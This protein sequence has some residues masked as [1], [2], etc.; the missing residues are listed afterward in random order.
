MAIQYQILYNS[1]NSC[2]FA[3]RTGLHLK[4]SLFSSNLIIYILK[5]VGLFLETQCFKNGTLKLIFILTF[6]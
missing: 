3:Y 6:R 1:I 4:V 2:H 5:F